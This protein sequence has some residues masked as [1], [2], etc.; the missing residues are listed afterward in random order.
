MKKQAEATGVDTS[1]RGLL[2]QAPGMMSQATDALAQVQS[3]KDEGD[4]L[5][6]EGVPGTAKLLAVRDAGMTLGG[7]AVGGLDNPVA[8]LDLEVTLEGSESYRATITQMVPR[9]AVGRLIPGTDLPVKVDP[10]DH[11]KLLVDW[12]APVPEAGSP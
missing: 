12:E 11:S 3:G 10:M 5:R 6:A 1:L 7:G 4:R 9:L 2:A 8:V